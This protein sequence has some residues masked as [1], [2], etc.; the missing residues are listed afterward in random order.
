MSLVVVDAGILIAAVYPETF[1]SQAKTLLKHLRKS[2]TA[3]YAPTLMRYELI[4]VARKAVYQARITAEEGRI[5]RDQLLSYPVT[6]YMDD[7]YELAEEF[8]RP[9]AYDAQYLALAERLGCEFWTTD[10]RMFNAVNAKF[11]NIRW[12]GTQPKR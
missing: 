1:T 5:A 2:Q 8:N 6:L 4:A 9:T 11:T 7:G 3:L 10:E 12:L